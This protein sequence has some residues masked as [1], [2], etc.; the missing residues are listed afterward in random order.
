M[1]S[2]REFLKFALGG[3]TAAAAFLSYPVG[4]AMARP[5]VAS[6][7]LKPPG[8]TPG[9]SLRAALLADLHA[10]SPWMTVDRIREIC[11]QTNALNPD[12]IL[13]L[14]DF[15]TAMRML[16]NTIAPDDWAPA[17][18]GLRAPL[19]VHAILGNHDYWHDAA[20]QR[21]T[22]VEPL[23]QTALT[24]VGIPV[25]VNKS[26]RL[27]KN[28]NPFWLAGLGD[29]LAVKLGI[30]DLPG[31]LSQITDAAPIILLAHEPDIFPLVT[32][33]VSITL[34]GHTHGGQV[35]IFGWRPIVPSNFGSRYVAGHVV[36]NGRHMIISRGLGCTG[37][38]LR[39][40]SPPEIVLLELN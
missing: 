12:I 22:S 13:L 18:S 20:F 8:W 36:E 7:R 6:Y 31:T 1:L 38:P 27:E 5:I 32:D 33:R 29:L 26:I 37:L 21:D 10:A 40:M 28:G 9:L 14:G 35:N 4:E 15:S 30:D 11:E 25:Y 19:G 2:R 17:L 23:A 39:L 3:A 24:K 34:C 16:T